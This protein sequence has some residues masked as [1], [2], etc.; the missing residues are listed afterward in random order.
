MK[1]VEQPQLIWG[2]T[3]PSAQLQCSSQR[4]ASMTDQP[5]GR[6]ERVDLRDIWVSEATSFTPWLARPENLVVL[7][8]ALNID[9]ELEA[10]ERAVG[11]FRADILCAKISTPTAGW[12]SFDNI[13]RNIREKIS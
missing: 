12:S 9:L 6:L 13:K 10:Q 4:K 5:L 7:G 2:N 11:S 3:V 8:E 1:Q